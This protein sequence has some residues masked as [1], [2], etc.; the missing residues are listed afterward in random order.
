MTDPQAAEFVRETQI[1]ALAVT[2]GNVHGSTNLSQS[3]TLSAGGNPRK[4]MPGCMA[5]VD[6]PQT[7]IGQSI[8]LG[9]CKFNVNTEVREAYLDV[10]KSSNSLSSPDLLDLMQKAIMA[11][12]LVV[13]EKLQILDLSVRIYTVPYPKISRMKII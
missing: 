1:D 12:Q 5:L 13:S 11:M 3:W 8:Q 6:Y 10:L 9:V 4:L 2:I 7:M